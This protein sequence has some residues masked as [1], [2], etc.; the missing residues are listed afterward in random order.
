VDFDNSQNM[1]IEAYP[2][3]IRLQLQALALL[4]RDPEANIG[5]FLLV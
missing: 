2:L 4:F 1:G 5:R 3:V